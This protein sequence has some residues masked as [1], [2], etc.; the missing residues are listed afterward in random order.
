MDKSKLILDE[1][2]NIEQKYRNHRTGN[3]KYSEEGVDKIRCPKSFKIDSFCEI[4]ITKPRD[5]S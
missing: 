5:N 4:E 1:L 2:K 3:I